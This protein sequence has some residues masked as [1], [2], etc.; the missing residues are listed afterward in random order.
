MD[1][2]ER[3][4]EYCTTLGWKFSHGNKANLNL[5]ISNSIVGEINVLFDEPTDGNGNNPN[6]A[7]LDTTYTGE[8]MILVNSNLDNVYDN[9]KGQHPDDGKYR[10][11][12]APLK[13]TE[14]PKLKKLINC[15]DDLILTS[16][17]SKGVT[18]LFDRNMDGVFVTYSIIYNG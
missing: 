3:F 12:I 10:K 4:R 6:G 2:V 15:S 8:L 17:T 1:I 16:I 18:N 11:N 7:E 13:Y 5:I 14:L 9:Q